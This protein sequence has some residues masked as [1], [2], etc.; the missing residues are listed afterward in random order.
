MHTSYILPLSRFLITS[1]ALAG[2]TA[3]A[4]R[5]TLPTPIVAAPIEAP[6]SEPEPALVAET[7]AQ[8]ESASPEAQQD[9]LS[10]VAQAVLDLSKLEIFW[11]VDQRPERSPLVVVCDAL[12]GSDSH[13]QKFGRPVAIKRRKE[14]R[15]K[16]PALFLDVVERADNRIALEFEYPPEGVFGSAVF[17]LRGGHWEPTEVQVYE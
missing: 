4:P 13:L 7:P 6:T 2:C 16:E 1:V 5:P 9:P 14:L 17:G 3:A 15:P 12:E 10:E 8:E 11:H